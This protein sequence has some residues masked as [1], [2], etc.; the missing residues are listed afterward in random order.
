MKRVAFV[1][2]GQGSQSVGMGKEM[3][4]RYP[5]VKDLFHQADE[6]LDLS[7]TNLMFEGPEETLTNT[8]NAQPALLLTSSAIQ[9]VLQREGVQPVVTAGHSLGEYSA[10]VASGVLRVEDALPLV[11]TRGKLMEHAFPKGKGAMAAVLGLTTEQIQEA[12][13]QLGEEEVVDL[14]NLNCPG[15][16]VISGTKAGIDAAIPLLKD[17]GAKRVLPLNVSGPFHSRLMEPAAKDFAS[18]LDQVKLKNA[19]IP[20]FANVTAEKTTDQEMIKDL[21][22]KQLYSPVRF[23]EILERILEEDVDAVV[24]VGN[25]KV[26]TGLV[27]KVNRRTKTFSVQDPSSL[28]EFLQWYKEDA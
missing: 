17:S 23:H 5:E 14:A 26:L 22:V 16:V 27:K 3:Y 7:I 13:E 21:L 18:A 9:Q 20:I 25:G 2:P 4:D 10:L 1:F 8:E 28:E 24:E 12:L 19:D 6:W 11:Q 15:Q